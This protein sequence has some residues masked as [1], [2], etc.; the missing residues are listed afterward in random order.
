MHTARAGQLSSKN[1]L[2]E[3][4]FGILKPVVHSARS[5]FSRARRQRSRSRAL[6]QSRRRVLAAALGRRRGR[7]SCSR[8][9]GI[10][11]GAVSRRWQ[12]GS[13]EKVLPWAMRAE[14]SKMRVSR[15]EF[16]RVER[17]VPRPGRDAWWVFPQA[18]RRTETWTWENKSRH[19]H[20]CER[21]EVM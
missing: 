14:R 5:T 15:Q 2:F 20:R 8:G 12:S 10:L 11:L 21:A 13:R 7:V 16:P 6:F 19:A 4:D 9:R 3:I 17:Q 1:K 18:Q